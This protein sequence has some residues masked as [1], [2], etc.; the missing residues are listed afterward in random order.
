MKSGNKEVRSDGA[1]IEYVYDL[2]RQH[3]H[4]YDQG[5]H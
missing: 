2:D 4:E 1:L 5:H 3:E